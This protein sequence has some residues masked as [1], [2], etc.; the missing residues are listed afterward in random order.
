MEAGK[1]FGISPFGVEAQRILRLEKQHI[2][3][4]Q[5]TDALSNP[6]EANL[7]WAVKFDKPDF[8]GKRA[9][10]AIR[11]AGLRNQLVGFVAQ[12]R[13]GSRRG[14]PGPGERAD[15]SAG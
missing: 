9:L 11:D 2:I 1:E 4:T 10:L 3:V 5:D 12:R 13:N 6:L 7:A 14:S 8:V 15:P